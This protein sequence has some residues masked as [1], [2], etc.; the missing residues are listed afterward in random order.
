MKSLIKVMGKKW[1]GQRSS[2]TQCSTETGQTPGAGLLGA[3]VL[4]L[5]EGRVPEAGPWCQARRG[6]E[7]KQEASLHCTR[8]PSQVFPFL[9]LFLTL[10]PGQS[11]EH[12]KCAFISNT[13]GCPPPCLSWI[14]HW[15]LSASSGQ[16]GAPNLTRSSG[17][18]HEAEPALWKNP[19]GARS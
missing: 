11:Q 13:A 8:F 9:S 2:P 10:K 16:V 18:T 15:K 5:Q 3:Q 1:Q 14:L 19:A 17:R 4:F 7:R 12:A 6:A